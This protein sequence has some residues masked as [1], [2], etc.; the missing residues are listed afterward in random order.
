MRRRDEVDVVA[1]MS[2]RSIIT[3]PIASSLAKEPSPRWLISQFWQKQQN[4]LLL[5]KKIVPE[6][7]RPT[8]GRSSPKCPC[9]E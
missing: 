7:R 3:R 9:A 1:P 5:L 2:W 8:R 6:P 4:R